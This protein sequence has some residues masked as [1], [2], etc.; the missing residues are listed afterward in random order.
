ML[1]PD[2]TPVRTR[3]RWRAA[4]VIV[5]VAG[6]VLRVAYV[7]FSRRGSD[8][9]GDA[10]YYHLAANLLAD[11]EGF[12]HPYGHLNGIDVPGADHPPLYI[13]ILA[14]SS[15]L[16]IRSTTGHLLV[17]AI[18]GTAAIPLAAMVGKRM[19]ARILDTARGGR[20][21]GL[22]AAVLVAFYPNTWRYDG[23]LMSETVVV[24]SVLVVLLAVFWYLDG[25]TLGRMAVVGAS[26]GLASLA[27]SELLLLA[28]ILLPLVAIARPW[29]SS[30]ADGSIHRHRIAA[31]L[32]GGLVAFVVVAPWPIYNL[33]RFDT[34]VLFTTNA[35]GTFAV[36]N[37]DS[38]YA[39]PT[40]GYW[41]Y[42]CGASVMEREGI[43]P[44]RQGAEADEVLRK[45]GIT[46]MREHAGRLPVVVGARLGR[47]TGLYA[48]FNQANLDVAVEDTPRPVALAGVWTYWV[49]AAVAI[50]GGILA[51]R[52]RLRLAVLLAPVVVVIA[53]SAAFYA[54]TRFRAT[55]E[56]SL[57]IL[58]A[59][60][61]VTG[62][63]RWRNRDRQPP[64][65]PV[66]E[67]AVVDGV[68]AT[69]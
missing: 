32:V 62:Y 7:W 37:C 50:A 5:T 41:D 46:Y 30:D 3:R 59:L 67:A 63:D 4:I 64:P 21:A 47:I 35:G 23:T 36:A 18:V 58:A 17:S 9:G 65:E 34:P 6:L 26:L 55:A 56:P 12:V 13:V 29:T 20:A 68:A 2:D 52:E 57:C 38:V 40:L 25:P 69:N 33:S 44:L 27:R 45:E 54:T 61:L 31:L 39:G 42:L 53:A 1:A 43:D 16:G 15:L 14:L 48:P 22:V 51:R 49:I 24:V 19:G 60:A 10:L 8:F 11:G 66:S 28:A